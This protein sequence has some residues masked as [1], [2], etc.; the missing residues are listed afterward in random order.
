D[1]RSRIPNRIFSQVASMCDHLQTVF[2]PQCQQ[3]IRNNRTT[4][5]EPKAP[6]LRNRREDEDGL[7]G[8][9]PVANTLARTTTKWEISKFGQTLAKFF[10]PAF[11]IKT[12]RFRKIAL[13][14][15]H[16]MLAQ[17]YDGAGGR[18]VAVQRIILNRTSPN[19]PKRRI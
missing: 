14:A 4:G 18:D 16:H 17:Y 9:E 2:G 13:I 11:G 12:K 6:F 19:H 7:H 3:W 1:F 10:R 15:V 5:H 8:A